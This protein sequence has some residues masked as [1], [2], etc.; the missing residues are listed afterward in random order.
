MF[1]GAAEVFSRGYS[2]ITMGVLGGLS[3]LVIHEM[4]GEIIC[5]RTGK[6]TSALISAFFIT[7]SELLAGEILNRYMHLKIWN[8]S[9]QLMNFDGQICPGYSLMWLLLAFVG[10]YVDRGIRK[11]IFHENSLSGSQTA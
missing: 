7:A 2:H 3:F 4:N 8:Y 10:L 6:L 5:G 1:Y 9:K 11:Y